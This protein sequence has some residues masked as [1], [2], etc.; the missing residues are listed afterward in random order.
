[1]ARYRRSLPTVDVELTASPAGQMIGQHFTIRSD[2]RLR[3]RDAQGVLRLPADFSEYLRGRHRQAVRTNVGHARRA[4]LR[5]ES[6]QIDDWAPGDGDSRFGHIQPGPVEWWLAFDSDGSLVGEAILSVDEDASL[7]H[8][9]TTTVT[10]ARWM[11]HAAIVERLCGHCRVLLVNSD[12]AY[13]LSAGNQHFQ[14]LLG[15]DIAR[16]RISP[17]PGPSRVV[18]TAPSL[19]LP[20]EAADL[21]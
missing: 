20:V 1:L 12:E 15:Y 5:V 3:Y 13:T 19:E 11:L 10:F 17:A 8:G 4:G 2:G 16:V 9:L 7:L 18:F 14:R 6:R 21:L